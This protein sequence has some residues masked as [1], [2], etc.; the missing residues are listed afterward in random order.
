MK[1]DSHIKS[2][3]GQ[4]RST[5]S[6][7]EEPI[8]EVIGLTRTKNSTVI[9]RA[10]GGTALE[11]HTASLLREPDIISMCGLRSLPAPA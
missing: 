9:S 6:F 1:V 2:Q 11:S 4:R 7:E 8:T 10:R 3:A 5:A